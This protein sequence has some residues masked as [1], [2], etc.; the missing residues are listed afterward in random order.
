MI[1]PKVF[2]TFCVLP[3]IHLSTH[4]NGG[5]SLCCRSNHTDAISWAKDATGNLL[6]LNNCKLS[7]IYNSDKFCE[8]REKMMSGI[9]PIECE[10][11]WNDEAAGIKSK[12]QYENEKWNSIFPQ[13][14]T[15]ARL[16]SL[17][18]KYIELRLG[19]VCNAA[20]MTCNAF[21]S[22]MWKP[23]EKYISESVPWFVC[24]TVNDTT[25]CDDERFYQDLLEHSNEVEEIYINGGEP[26][27]IKAHYNYLQ[28]I[29]D[30]GLSNKIKLIYSLNM[31]SLPPALLEVW[32]NF[33]SIEVNASIDDVNE[34]N[35]YIR[36]PTK[37]SSVID[38][39][40]KLNSLSNVTWH[41]TQTVSIFNIGN[42][43]KLLNLL[44]DDYGVIPHYN[45]V[46]Y[47]DYLSLAALPTMYKN[48]LQ[49]KYKDIIPADQYQ[50]LINKLTVA[51]D[52]NLLIRAR[53][54][55]TAIDNYRKLS[56]TEYIPE[57][58][59]FL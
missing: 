42:L 20:C 12:R 5:S 21:S 37:W 46:L 26:T 52:N 43:D 8:V 49:K 14:E 47:P 13:L 51:F 22:S 57:L 50:T 34:R 29:I 30:Q 44:R 1:K 38:T 3:W 56:Y 31:T 54:F 9:K 16:S 28:Q 48:E 41:V 27:L 15:E 2:C 35:Y 33:K 10:G 23:Q 18:Y 32:K 25:W 45:Y 7:D 40:N 11:C 17:Q 55:I 24:N 59:K 6:T 19:D 58:G 36:Y 53:E 4:P 39:L